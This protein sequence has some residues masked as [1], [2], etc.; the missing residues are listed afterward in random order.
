MMQTKSLLSIGLIALLFLLVVVPI[1]HGAMMGDETMSQDCF[2]QCLFA[3]PLVRNEVMIIP[4]TLIMALFMV[5]SVVIATFARKPLRAGL[6]RLFLYF[7][8]HRWRLRLYN[9]W[10]LLLSHGIIARRLYA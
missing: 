9:I 8:Y 7:R 5:V 2:R 6:Q 3:V 4:T 1:N 10:T